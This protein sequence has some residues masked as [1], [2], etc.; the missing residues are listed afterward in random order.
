MI[1]K[2]AYL[3]IAHNECGLLNK[4]IESIDDK[5][6]DIFIHVDRKADFRINDLYKPQKS[7]LFP[8]KQTNIQW[9]GDTQIK[10]EM[11]LLKSAR[12]KEHYSYYHLL[13]G[14]D[15]PIKSQ[16]EIHKFFEK[17]KGKNYIKIDPVAAKSAYHNERIRYYYFFQNLIGK[18]HGHIVGGLYK[19]QALT[20]RLQKKLR[21]NRLKKCSKRIYKGTNWFSIT[22]EMV[23]EILREES[24]IKKYCYRSLCADEIFVQTVAM[25]SDLKGTVVDEDLRCIDWKRGNPWIWRMEDAAYLLSQD[26]NL[27]ARKF[28]DKVDEKI[29]SF[30]VEKVKKNSGGYSS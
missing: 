6:N 5:R 13:S 23:Q 25:N 14:V 20:L 28:S 8:I 12:Q 29:S 18:K 26:S 10:C 16:D 2:H 15:L 19:L 17:N 27:F 21:I 9:G 11:N 3:I 7:N 30:I 4:L 1:E 22:D 24:F